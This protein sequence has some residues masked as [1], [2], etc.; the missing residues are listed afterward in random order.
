MELTGAATSKS[1]SVA[2]RIRETM[3]PRRYAGSA[4][5]IPVDVPGILATPLSPFQ[6]I[7]Q[8]DHN[9]A[10]HAQHLQPQEMRCAPLYVE[11]FVQK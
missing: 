4:A 8:W 7:I 2:H 9:I 11:V 5:I 6:Q 10:V 3:R 1:H